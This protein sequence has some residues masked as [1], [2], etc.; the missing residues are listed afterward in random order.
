MYECNPAAWLQ[1]KAG[2]LAV[3]ADHA[4]LDIVPTGIHHRVPLVI[5]SREDVEEYVACRREHRAV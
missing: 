2:G 4:V 5:G 3:D 1:E